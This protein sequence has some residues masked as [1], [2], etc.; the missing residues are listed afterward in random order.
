[1]FSQREVKSQASS[2]PV[3]GSNAPPMKQNGMLHNGKSK[4]CTSLLTGAAFVHPIETFE[5][6][7][8]LFLFHT[9]SIVFESNTT[10]C[11]VVL[12]Q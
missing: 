3:A 1:M 9:Y 5:Q 7:G 2:R 6:A 11:S 8:Q 12:D 10:L 4:S